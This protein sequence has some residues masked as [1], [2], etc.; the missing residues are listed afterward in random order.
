M[1]SPVPAKPGAKDQTCL[2]SQKGRKLQRAAKG[3]RCFC[4]GWMGRGQQVRHSFLAFLPHSLGTGAFTSD[5]NFE[6][7]VDLGPEKHVLALSDVFGEHCFLNLEKAVA[8][9]SSN[10]AWKIPWTEE[11]GGL[12]SIGSLRVR[13]D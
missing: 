1:N 9:H 13:H 5:Q 10:L 8:P 7:C 2:N 6:L 3:T 12:Q 11:P 4:S